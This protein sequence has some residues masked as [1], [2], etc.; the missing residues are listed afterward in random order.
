MTIIK[1]FRNKKND[2]MIAQFMGYHL[3]LGKNEIGPV[4]FRRKMKGFDDV[5]EHKTNLE[6]HKDWNLLM[7]VVE[8]ILTTDIGDNDFC[9]T[10]PNLRTFGMVN[11]TSGKMMVRFEGH[12][13]FEE[14]TLKEATYKAV[15]NFIKNRSSEDV[16]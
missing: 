10:Y 13:L 15:V 5:Y 9:A 4:T 1:R 11:Q 7:E 14:K 8:K 16:K 2:Y 12:S 6:Y 3:H